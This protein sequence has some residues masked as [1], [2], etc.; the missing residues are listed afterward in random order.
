M[1]LGLLILGIILIVISIIL[2]IKYNNDEN[3][4]M[5]KI[6][7]VY[8]EIDEYSNALNDII[9]NLEYLMKDDKIE[10]EKLENKDIK[11]KK[12]KEEHTNKEYIKENTFKED[13]LLLHKNGKSKDEIAK[14]L[15]KGKREIEIIL[16]LNDFNKN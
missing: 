8:D 7:Q 2:L 14:I 5:M 15:N 10:E 13:I 9:S 12:I 1:V 6:N 4:K 11:E 16:K 3:I